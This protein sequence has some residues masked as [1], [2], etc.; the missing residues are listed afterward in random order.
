M[1]NGPYYG[2]P[3][4]VRRLGAIN[5]VANIAN[6]VNSGLQQYRQ[7]QMQSAQMGMNAQRM[8]SIAALNQMKMQKLQQD[9]A[10]IQ[11]GAQNYML[12]KQAADAGLAPDSMA[13]KALAD[14]INSAKTPEQQNYIKQQLSA[15]QQS[16]MQDT[17]KSGVPGYSPSDTIMPQ[18]SRIQQNAA[19]SVNQAMNDGM[20]QQAPAAPQPNSA[21]D[22]KNK[23]YAQIDAINSRQQQD[24]AQQFA[25]TFNGLSPNQIHAAGMAYNGFMN[26]F[27]GQQ[28]NQNQVDAT[29]LKAMT[30][31]Y[32]NNQK[33][34]D[35]LSNSDKNNEA[36]LHIANLKAQNDQIVQSLK[37]SGLDTSGMYRVQA[38]QVGAN[39][40]LGAATTNANARVNSAKIAA[41]AKTAAGTNDPAAKALMNTATNIQNQIAQVDKPNAMGMTPLP[42]DVA[43][44]KQELQDQ[45]NGV[46]QVYKKQYGK[47]LSL[48][49]N[50]PS[51]PAQGQP[52]SGA[53]QSPSAGQMPSFSRKDP[54]VIDSLKKL[55][56]GSPFLL[57]GASY[58]VSN[59]APVPLNAPQAQSS[60]AQ[61]PLAMPDLSAYQQQ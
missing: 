44:R 30:D 18:G 42:D 17:S 61:S 10:P 19:S 40:R 32:V 8:Q 11:F 43:K 53:P 5:G 23:I 37:N 54:G 28:R 7:Y 9:L 22:A 34:I 35:L 48:P 58:K 49:G 33:S 25:Q 13:H 41:G 59:G 52:Q 47:D 15:Y 27:N 26:G 39:A 46:Y 1:A 56:E 36:K 24:P 4:N 60:S 57:D 29:N 45:L 6:A 55:P 16:Q 3:H 31:V 21:D 12:K 51:A 50:Q 20:Q 2:G 14:V 38:A